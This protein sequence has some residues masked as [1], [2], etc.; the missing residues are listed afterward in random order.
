MTSYGSSFRPAAAQ[1][2]ATSR[3]VRA[4][5]DKGGR[6]ACLPLRLEN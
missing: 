4:L 6:V 1:A 3:R 5:P 2:W